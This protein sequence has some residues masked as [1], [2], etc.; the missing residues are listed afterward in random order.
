MPRVSSTTPSLWHDDLG[1]RAT[2]AGDC[3]LDHHGLWDCRVAV[4]DI[5][6]RDAEDQDIFTAAKARDAVVMTKDRDFVEL[7]QRHGSPPRVIW[8]ACG[9]TSNSRLRDILG[10]T[11][12]DA[13]D[14]VR[15]GEPLV[16]ISGL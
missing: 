15:A 9:N 7:V 14:L 12:A 1:G 2:T 13:L 11:L 8:L 4:C 5:G 3:R 10:M 6:L 16:E